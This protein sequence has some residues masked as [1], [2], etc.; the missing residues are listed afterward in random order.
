VGYP[1]VEPLGSDIVSVAQCIAIDADAFPY[2]SEDLVLASRDTSSLVWV[3]RA[4]P[5]A[6]VIGFLVARMKHD[7]L[8]ISGVAADRAHRREGVGRALLREAK[9]AARALDVEGIVLNV[10][11]GNRAAI[12]LYQGEGFVTRREVRGLYSPSV[13][14]GPDALEMAWATEPR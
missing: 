4:E 9:D 6:R 12:A 1:L 3:A 5:H 11:R 13:E 8:F 7:A 14:G 10:A 2:P